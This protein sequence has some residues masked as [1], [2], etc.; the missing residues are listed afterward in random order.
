VSLTYLANI[1][2]HQQLE[3]IGGGIM[4]VLFDTE[5]TDGQLTVLRSRLPRGSAAPVHVHSRE[6]E[7]FVLLKGEAVFWA[8]DQ[9]YELVEGGVAFLPRNVPHTYR[10]ISAE[11]DILT[12]CV[13]S[14]IETFFRTAGHDLATPKPAGWQLTPASMAA[15][16]ELVGQRIIG[17][18]LDAD[19]H[20]PTAYLQP[21]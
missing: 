8:G 21:S 7:M 10:F 5:S 1:A 11:A 6:D 20:M 17:P 3:W 15:A 4:S 14:G 18:P 9:R 16:A 13:P 2:D 12:L 19:D